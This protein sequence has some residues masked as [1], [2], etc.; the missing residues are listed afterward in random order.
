MKAHQ[1]NEVKLMFYTDQG[2]QMTIYDLIEE[3][4]LAQDHLTDKQIFQ[5]ISCYPTSKW[6]SVSKQ[7]L[8]GITNKHSLYGDDI[9]KLTGIIEFYHNTG[10]IT[11]K[12]QWFVTQYLIRNW[13]QLDITHYSY[14]M[15]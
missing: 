14:Y 7:F 9:Y 8:K 3:C 1:R 13:H 15:T 4:H 2:N 12:Q 5:V 6:I 10:E 11:H